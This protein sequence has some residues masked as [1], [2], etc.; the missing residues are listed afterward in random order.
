MKSPSVKT[1]VAMTDNGLAKVH[2]I[3]IDLADI[4]RSF[5]Q[6]GAQIEKI[7]QVDAAHLRA[8]TVFH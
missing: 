6:I 5:Q 3:E 2:K 1:A 4:K 7:K 8:T